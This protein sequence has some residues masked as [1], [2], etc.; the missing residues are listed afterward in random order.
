MYRHLSSIQQTALAQSPPIMS[1]EDQKSA[2]EGI[3][4]ENLQKR[5]EKV[6]RGHVAWLKQA[7]KVDGCFRA[8]YWVTG[9]LIIKGDSNS[10]TGAESLTD[11]PFQLIKLADYGR[12]FKLDKDGVFLTELKALATNWIQVLETANA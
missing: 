2:L 4:V 7:E 1:S 10:D 12:L 11:T 9:K 5:I 6:C 3:C 8:N